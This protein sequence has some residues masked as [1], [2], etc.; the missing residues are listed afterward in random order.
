MA[1]MAEKFYG[2][3]E[4]WSPRSKPLEI[5]IEE[6]TDRK[7][8]FVAD[9]ETHT[10][11]NALRMALLEDEDVLFVAYKLEHPLKQRVIFV[12]QTKKGDPV[13]AIDRALKKLKEK[14]DEFKKNMLKAVSQK[15][16]NPYFIPEEEWNKFVE[17]NI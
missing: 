17:E 16:R 15:P 5:K 7:L 4:F 12:L 6:K 1:D 3:N 10:L 8:K 11:F 2:K 13:E 9:G 14:F